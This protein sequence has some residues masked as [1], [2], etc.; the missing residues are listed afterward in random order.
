MAYEK[1]D[2]ST[3]IR[4][5]LSLLSYSNLTAVGIGY[6]FESDNLE[7]W[8]KNEPKNYWNLRVVF[9]PRD[10]YVAWVPSKGTKWRNIPETLKDALQNSKIRVP[11]LVTLGSNGAYIV[12]WPDG[13]F[14]YSSLHDYSGLAVAIKSNNSNIA[15][16]SCII[17]VIS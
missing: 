8:I 2:G 10:S 13:K 12:T 3:S 4:G 9:G 6:D 14:K 15:V 16:R 1:R 5:F 11:S 7:Q 17:F